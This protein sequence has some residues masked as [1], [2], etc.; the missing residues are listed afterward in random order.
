MA[1]S[2]L[3]PMPQTIDGYKKL[4]QSDLELIEEQQK[5]IGQLKATIN[6]LVQSKT[7]KDAL[8]YR[9]M[10]ESGE[11]DYMQDWICEPKCKVDALIDENINNMVNKL[12]KGNEDE[13]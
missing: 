6:K 7:R 1:S 9:Y 3:E 11:F 10:F 5:E 12:I 13:D 4:A 8:R 2:T